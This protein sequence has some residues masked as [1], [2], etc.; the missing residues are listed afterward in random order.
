MAL[1]EFLPLASVGQAVLVPQACCRMR[2]MFEGTVTLG[3]TT[4]QTT[5]IADFLKNFKINNLLHGAR[6]Q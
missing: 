3:Q 2:M 5:Q 6:W 4:S 1:H